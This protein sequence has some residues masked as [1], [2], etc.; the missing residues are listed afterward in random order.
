MKYEKLA[1]DI[2][3]NV[4]GKENVVS[5]THCITRLRFKL[6]DE[7]K[8]NTEDLKNMD[9]VVTVVKGGGQYQVVIGN[10]VPDVYEEVMEIGGFNASASE[11][12]EENKSI[13]NKFIDFISGV[14]APTL[15]VLTAT[16]MIK[17]FNAL[18]LSLGWIT[19]QSGTYQILQVIGDCFLY[20]FPIF[21]GYTAA[22][23]FKMNE[24]VG[25]AIGSCLVYPALSSITAGKALFT[26]FKGTA[27]AAPVYIKFLGIPVILMNYSSS[28]IPILLATYFAAKIEKALKKVMP[29]VVKRFMVPALTLLI[30]VPITFIVIGPIATWISKFM[31]YLILSA[32]HISPIIAG[33]IIGGTWQLLVVCG[34]HWG[35]VP[36]AI[37]NIAS[38]GYDTV[39]A[40]AMGTPLAT[41]GV[42]FAIFVKTRDKNLKAISAPAW[43]SSLFGVSEPSIY[44]VT[45]PRKKPF[46]I[47]LIS[48]AVA[49]GIMG[50]SG[51]KMYVMGGMGVFGIPN[52]INPKNGIDKGFYGYIVALAVAFI[53]G[54]ILTFLLGF[55]D[56]A[57]NKKIAKD[58]TIEPLVKQEVIYSPLKGEVISLSEIE[59]E[60]FSREALGKGIAIKPTEGKIVA[61]ADGIITTLFPTKHAIGITTDKGSEIL[62][63]V[64]MN[65]VN[66]NGKY[67]NA[68]VNQ[69]DRVKKGDVILE[70]DTKALEEQGYSTV[71]PVI[72][73]NTEKYLDV[74]ETDSKSVSYGDSLLTL[75]I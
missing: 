9:G 57:E 74:I 55:K 6:K 40:L 65:T 72:I 49:G 30:I 53:L 27:I 63:H 45:L 26:L 60:A 61:P 28:V 7:N 23:K 51:T 10:H 47:T 69:E 12:V 17:G 16:G 43:I 67:F 68:K 71:T 36:I 22:K 4:G 19:K 62:I 42:V 52:Y 15:G 24:F 58:E 48:A 41:A 59:D 3:K 33:I 5:L 73:T 1:K 18:F 35:I 32:Y 11:E 44:G 46:I 38:L 64:G 50:F 54:F 66:L 13:L 31:G 14:F 21:L 29:D 34:L 2:I 75:I 20:F 70:F 37:N 56:E 39:M 25:M 8:A